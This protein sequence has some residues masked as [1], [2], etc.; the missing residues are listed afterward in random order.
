MGENAHC[1]EYALVRCLSTRT[2]IFV[3]ILFSACWINCVVSCPV[4]C[5]L[6]CSHYLRQILDALKYCHSKKVMHGNV[7]P[8]CLLLANKEN[9]AS[10][11]LGGFGNALDLNEEGSFP[12]GK[13]VQNHLLLTLLFI[14]FIVGYVQKVIC[15]CPFTHITMH[16]C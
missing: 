13:S 6:H 9:S 12:E 16:V 3:H 10:V 15:I 11:K 4:C 2:E 7:R 1:Q 8:H 5:C 14:M